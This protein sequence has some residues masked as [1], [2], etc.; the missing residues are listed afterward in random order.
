[1]ALLWVTYDCGSLSLCGLDEESNELSSGY[2]VGREGRAS[3]ACLAS[4]EMTMIERQ[5]S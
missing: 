2:R 5:N 1:M 4:I 3:V